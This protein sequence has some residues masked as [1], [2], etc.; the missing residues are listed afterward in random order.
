MGW[1]EGA[2][3]NA[4]RFAAHLVHW[5]ESRCSAAQLRLDAPPRASAARRRGWRAIDETAHAG[6][7]SRTA[8][9][10]DCGSLFHCEL[11]VDCNKVSPSAATIWSSERLNSF[12]A[13][14]VA[15]NAPKMGG[16]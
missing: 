2:R 14:A 10:A 12:A 1:L 9:T 7:A 15:P 6:N 8:R 4:T 16:V 13:V 11:K 5:H 3:F